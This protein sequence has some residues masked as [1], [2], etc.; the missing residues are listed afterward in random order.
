MQDKKDPVLKIVKKRKVAYPNVYGIVI[1]VEPKGEYR[2]KIEVAYSMEEA[3]DA[4]IHELLHEYGDVDEKNM[5]AVAWDK[6]G[7]DSL[8]NRLTKFK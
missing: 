5:T 1:H 3:V 8:M 4:A 2:I 6:V 7:H